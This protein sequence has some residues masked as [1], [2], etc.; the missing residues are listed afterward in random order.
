MRDCYLFTITLIAISVLGDHFFI[1]K[2]IKKSQRTTGYTSIRVIS[3]SKA[4]C[5]RWT[6]HQKTNRNK[7]WSIGMWFL[8]VL[9]H[10]LFQS[11]PGPKSFLTKVAR[12]GDSLQMF[13]LNVVLQISNYCLLSTAL[14]SIQW[15]TIGTHF[16]S[17]F[18]H[19][20]AFL[21]KLMEIPG[22]VIHRC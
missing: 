17:L 8:V 14:A 13:C 2:V 18:H 1:L 6:S 10:V 5:S 3:P 11:I 4:S 22:K 12:D 21:V 16:C 15:F 20:V 9:G 19:W 7:T